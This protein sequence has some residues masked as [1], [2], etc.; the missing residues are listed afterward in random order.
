[1]TVC[2][3]PL[4]EYSD[5]SPGTRGHKHPCLGTLDTRVPINTPVQGPEVAKFTELLLFPVELYKHSL[6]PPIGFTGSPEPVPTFGT[7]RSCYEQTTRDGTQ[8]S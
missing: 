7:H 2:N 1:M 8:E 5:D 6:H 4:W 3:L